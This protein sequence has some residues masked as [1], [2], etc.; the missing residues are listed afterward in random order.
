MKGQTTVR[1]AAAA[2]AVV[3]LLLV[4]LHLD[5]AASTTIPSGCLY[6]SGVFTCDYRFCTPLEPSMFDPAPQRLVIYNIDGGMN[7]SL[8]PSWNTMNSTDFDSNYDASLTLSC[9]QGGGL[10]ELTS[11][12]F[13]PGFQQLR[14]AKFG[15]QGGKMSAVQ[16]NAFTGFT[17]R[18]NPNSVNPRGEL[19]IIDV[20]FPSDTFPTGL[21]SSQ[22]SVTTLTLHK[23]GLNTVPADFLTHMT[24]LTTLSLDFNGFT[25][26]PS[27]LFAGL[28]ALTTLNAGGIHWD[29]TCEKLWWIDYVAKHSM[30]ITS[31][32]LC[33]QPLSYYGQRT[34][35]YHNNACGKGL[36]CDEGSLPAVNLGD[37][38]C[39]T[40]LQIF[41]YTLAVL[42]F[43]GMSVVAGCWFQTRR[44]LKRNGAGGGG[45][46]K[47]GGFTPRRNRVGGAPGGRAAP[48]GTKAGW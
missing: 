29:C 34:T 26:L 20:E 23:S 42:G 12:S 21:L 19:S 13:D 43:F 28:S 8:F 45:G 46:G 4:T 33:Y 24:N 32:M 30:R 41:I 14:R 5:K 39:L 3:A 18:R 44:Q 22:A 17:V 48:P 11:A 36:Q 37:V 38:T 40:Y 27:T 31:E 1:T 25:E 9:L 15:I 2:T 7:A 35:M 10:M 16:G 6:S 47:G